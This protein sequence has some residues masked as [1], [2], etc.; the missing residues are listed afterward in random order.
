MRLYPTRGGGG[1][2]AFS[3]AILSP[4]AAFGGLYAPKELPDLGDLNALKALSYVQLSRYILKLFETDLDDKAIDEALKTYDRF[5]D[6][7]EPTPL[8]RV[9]D[10]LFIQ[11]LWRGPTRAFKDM[12]LQPFG[13]ILSNFALKRGEKYAILT[14]TSGDTGPATLEAF[15]DRA[16]TEVVCLY[17]DGGASEAQIL[18]MIAQTAANLKVIAIKGNFDDAQDAL[19]KLLSSKSF[20]ESTKANGRKLSAA[21]SVNFG[22]ILFQI[23][24]HIRGYLQL[25]QRGEI[26]NG[27]TIDVIVPSGNFGNALGAYYARKIGLPIAKIVVVSNDNNV[28]TDLIVAGKYDLTQR[29]LIATISPA[30]DILKSSNAER[31]LFDLFGEARTKTFMEN[32]AQNGAFE[33]SPSE[34]RLLQTIFEAAWSNESE[35]FAAMRQSARDGYI[36]DPHTATCFKALKLGVSR[37]K[38]ICSTAEWTKFAP[39]LL[40]AISGEQK[41]DKEALE[42]ISKRFNLAVSPAIANLFAKKTIAPAPIAPNQI[43]AD[44]LEWLSKRP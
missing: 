31:I 23:I 18:Q 32:L 44:V 29:K 6:P 16:D 42:I 7:K 20:N 35:T 10:Q 17:P 8:V 21:N 11:E 5:D 37:V 43:E 25:L 4:L 2:I 14:A 39:I 22:R 12:A 41:G 30:M 36:V 34:L 1:S 28:L 19:K 24:Y 38:V 27:E 33:L 9:G 15:A 40:K 13:A 26:T 3:E